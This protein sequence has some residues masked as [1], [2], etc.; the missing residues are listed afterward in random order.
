MY[1]AIYLIC[2]NCKE[3]FPLSSNNIKNNKFVFNTI[4]FYYMIKSNLKITALSNCRVRIN[5][6][7]L[8]RA[9]KNHSAT[10]SLTA[11]QISFAF[12]H[13]SNNNLTS[14]KSLINKL[15]EQSS[16]TTKNLLNN[17]FQE[18]AKKPFAYYNVAYHTP[19]ASRQF[20][21]ISTGDRK[22]LF[23]CRSAPNK[24]RITIE[25]SPG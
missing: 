16:R 14:K 5:D 1:F 10:H 25:Q 18:N 21:Q 8:N 12:S 23:F 20:Y 13:V 11:N 15:V 19:C 3:D 22:S 6:T 9:P 2:K 7:L 17:I 4:I 24:V